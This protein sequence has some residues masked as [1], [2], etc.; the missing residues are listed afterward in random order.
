[1]LN[2]PFKFTLLLPSERQKFE[3]DKFEFLNGHLEFDRGKEF[4]QTETIAVVDDFKEIIEDLEKQRDKAYGFNENLEKIIEKQKQRIKALTD[5]GYE[6]KE[7]LHNV[8]DLRF[9][10]F[11]ILESFRGKSSRRRT[12]IE[13]LMAEANSREAQEERDSETNTGEHSS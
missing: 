13:A 11:K 7:D 8:D 9:Y 1:M 5:I 10:F 6:L 3:Q 2:L 4:A 12:L